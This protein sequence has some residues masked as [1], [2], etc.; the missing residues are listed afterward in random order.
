MPIQTE[1]KITDRCFS[2]LLF[3]YRSLKEKYGFC[4]DE[5]PLPPVTGWSGSSA[6]RSSSLLNPQRLA[7][8]HFSRGPARC[9]SHPAAAQ[10]HAVQE[11]TG[12]A[13]PRSHRMTFLV[14]KIEKKRISYT[15]QAISHGANNKARLGFVYWLQPTS[16]KCVKRCGMWRWKLLSLHI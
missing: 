9:A 6:K 16:V 12:T 10:P 2:L 11:Q 3:P 8:G 14:L 4:L 15:T 7:Q 13:V 5:Q 1:D